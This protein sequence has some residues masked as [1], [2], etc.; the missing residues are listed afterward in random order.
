MTRRWGAVA[1]VIA[2]CWFVG[3]ALAAPPVPT[4]LAAPSA[5]TPSS[6]ER[7]RASFQEGYRHQQAKAYEQ[8][9]RAYE[10]SLRRDPNQPEALSNLGF[11]Y[12]SLKRYQKAI[13][14]YKDAIRLKPDLA[15]AHEYLGEAYVAL[16]KLDLAAREY[17]TLVKLGSKEAE[18]LKEKIDAAT[19]RE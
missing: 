8:A 14:F 2:G 16:G 19:E 12:K 15:E 3:G 5:R 17:R 11:C 9:I 18:E 13:G 10:A 7:A 4:V 6:E 1:V